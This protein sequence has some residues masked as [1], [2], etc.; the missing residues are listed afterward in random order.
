MVKRKANFRRGCPTNGK[1]D[2]ANLNRQAPVFFLINTGRASLMPKQSVSLHGVVFQNFSG[3]LIRSRVC[4]SF[5]RGGSASPVGNSGW[6]PLHGVVFKI[7]S[8]SLIRRLATREA[9]LCMGCFQD[10]FRQPQGC[11]PTASLGF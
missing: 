7:F 5:I 6:R 1:A 2:L 4:H 10:F 9:D 8:G 11:T 3:S